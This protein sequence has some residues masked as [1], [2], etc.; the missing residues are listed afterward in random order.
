MRR[1]L[2][3]A[4][5][6]A[7]SL[8]AQQTIAPTNEAVGTLR[9]DDWHGLNIR[10]SF[11][12]GVRMLSVDGSRERYRS[13][14]NYRN[15]LRLL[16]STFEAKSKNGKGKWI[17]ELVVSTQGLGNDP[18]QMSSVRASKNGAYRYDMTWRSNEYFNPALPIAEG[19][20][21]LNT[22]RRLQDHNITLLP[23]SKWR[24]LA[25]YTRNGQSGAGLTTINL[26]DQ[27]R[28]TE[29]PL[30]SNIR[31]RQNEFRVGVEGSFAGMKLIAMRSWERFND[32]TA[33]SAANARPYDPSN[34]TTLT[35]LARTNPIDGSADGW[36][37]NLFTEAKR[38]YA[39][40]ARFTWV[41]G[42]RSFVTD[43][44]ALGTNR[45]G[46]AQDRQVV[47]SGNAR[48]PVLASNATIS[49]FPTERLTIT[50]HVAFTQ[51]RME[52]D[53]VY[54]DFN[55][56][57][58]ALRFVSLQFLG[59]RMASNTID[60]QYQATRWL[61]IHGGYHVAERRV[62]SREDD[63]LSQQNN[64]LNA[65][66]FGLRFRRLKGFSAN[67]DGELG[68]ADNP[69]LPLSERNYHALNSRVEYRTK[70][71]RVM[72]Q[73][74][75]N[76]NFNSVSLWAHSARSRQY[77]LDASWTGTNWLSFDA[78]YSKLHLDTL[79]GLAYFAGFNLVESDRSY[80]VS[81]MH[82]TFAGL[83]LSIRKKADIFGGWTRVQDRGG[84]AIAVS[85]PAFAAA[86]MFPFVFHSPMLR[87]SIPFSAKVRW[88][89]GYQHYGYGERLL[90]Q[91]NYRA[92]TAYTS[93]LWSF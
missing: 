45:F 42:E 83:R 55:N 86:Q 56:R 69:F 58:A 47:V 33:D 62:R 31:R 71:V 6:V 78:G 49:L 93:L 18:Y 39:L 91:Q 67:I 65:G 37:A 27:H 89:A 63:A 17:D 61:S 34:A 64:R 76:Y 11:E 77:G 9:G 10:E 5:I 21:L 59:V 38:W 51:A 57:T 87:L 35:R 41:D 28:G 12:V 29:F 24:I 66:Q 81:N 26:F 75:S 1:A 80:Y 53:S 2:V 14:V 73:A 70:R 48:R 4:A 88:N 8:F 92:Q 23:D 40:N 82:T 68:R 25:G 90:P 32:E 84:R 72:A 30:F 13:D 46:G 20:H 60:A 36:R 16:G 3:I 50:N 54:R 74:R 85:L 79:T 44:S 43:E 7:P 22:T 19:R 15:G 52:G